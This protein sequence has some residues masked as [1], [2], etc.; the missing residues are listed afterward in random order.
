M[1]WARDLARPCTAAVGAAHCDV[2]SVWWEGAAGMPLKGL[3]APQPVRDHVSSADHTGHQV[4]HILCSCQQCRQLLQAT[5]LLL[6]V[7]AVLHC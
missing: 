6:Q 1:C 5:A 7:L 4:L 3:A 2:P